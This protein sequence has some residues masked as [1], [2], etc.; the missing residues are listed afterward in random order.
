[1]P[2]QTNKRFEIQIRYRSQCD[3]MKAAAKGTI[4]REG[5]YGEAYLIH[6]AD[7]VQH[8]T[9][10]STLRGDYQKPDGTTATACDFGK[11]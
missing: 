5:K 1:M 11:K 9:K 10:I 8:K 6:S 7:G 2:D 3:E 4:D